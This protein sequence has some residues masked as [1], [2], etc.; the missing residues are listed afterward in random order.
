MQFVGQPDDVMVIGLAS[1]VTAG[2]ASL[3]PEVESLQIVELEPAIA[4]AAEFFGEWNHAVLSDPRVALVHNDAR[5]HLLLAEPES[6]N[7]IVSEPS[8]PWITGVSQLFTREF[9]EIGKSRL[10][11]GGAWSQWVPVYGM[12]SR[13][14]RS[15]LKTF[16][17]VF[18][19]VLVYAT[20][21]NA[22]LVL[23]GSESPL[24]P[25]ERVGN[26]LL[27][28]PLVAAELKRANI[29]SADELN[30][31]LLMDRADIVAMSEGVPLNT[32]DNMFVE[33][34]TA[35]KPHLDTGKENFAFLL[36]NSR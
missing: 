1:G 17:E 21:E 15:I 2:A 24:Q 11:P 30:S 31:L 7:V 32:D 34:S 5:N 3:V 26:R 4:R 36:R 6:Y 10:K 33:Y 20:I 14:L 16:A 18:P 27:D 28:R 12:D 35:K 13:D 25:A 19:H 9:L 22:D 23:V 29:N 8:N